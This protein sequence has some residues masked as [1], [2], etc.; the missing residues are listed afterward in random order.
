M[1]LVAVVL[2]V[3]ACSSGGATTRSATPRPTSRNDGPPGRPVWRHAT[4]G[5]PT[6]IATDW[7]STVV[8]SAQTVSDL[9]SDGNERWRTRIEHLEPVTPA[10]GTDLTVVA[11]TGGLV[12]LDRYEGTTRWEVD[13][14]GGTRVLELAEPRTGDPLLINSTEDGH[15]EGRAA[16]DGSVRWRVAGE[17]DVN[18]KFA[19]GDGGAVVVAMWSGV[20]ASTLRA[21][22]VGNG[23]VIWDR[24]IPRRASAPAIVQEDT[25]VV[26]AGDNDDGSQALAFGLA[27]GSPT[28]NLAVPGSFQTSVEP[29][30]Q[31]GEVALVDQLGTVTLVDAITRSITWQQKLGSP[32]IMGRPVLAD[33]VVV[34]TTFAREVVWLDRKTGDV[35]RRWQPGAVPAGIVRVGDRIVVALRLTQPGRVEA[36]AL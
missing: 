31:M 26:G 15:V 1:A 23:A 21:I 22:N 34:V 12:A 19:L 10:L 5:W 24:Q 32:V 6:R 33:H 9:E 2:L 27:D 25:V 20:D 13:V 18:A 36:Y 11:R 7:R 29:E 30:T 14:P 3:Q 16:A 4:N 28:W 8:T 17:G 35:I